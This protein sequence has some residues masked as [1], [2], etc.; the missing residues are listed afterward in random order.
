MAIIKPDRPAPMIMIFGYSFIRLGFTSFFNDWF[1]AYTTTI[2]PL[3]LFFKMGKTSFT[4]P[5]TFSSCSLDNSR[6][7]ISVGLRQNK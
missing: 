1:S 7:R 3:V 6:K 2:S 5:L 4:V